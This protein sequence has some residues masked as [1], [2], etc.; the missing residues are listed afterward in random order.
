MLSAL[1]SGSEIAFI[2][3]NK[4]GIEVLKNKGHKRGDLIANFYE[5]PREF[6]SAMVVGN[7]IVLVILTMLATSFLESYLLIYF[8]KDS[9]FLV[10]LITLVITV[11][12]LIFGEF[13]PKILSKLYSNEMLYR[14]AHLLNFFLILLKV[15]TW[16]MTKLSSGVLRLMNVSDENIGNEFSRVDLEVYLHES[17][18]QEQ[19]IDKEILSNVLNLN[20]L[21]V[22]DCYIPRNEIIYIDKSDSVDTAIKLFKEHKI[23]RIIVI[24][25][26]IEDIV[27]Y[28]HHQ[29]L[30]S[31]PKRL[32]KIILPITFIPE[33][34]ALPDAMRKF[35][36][37]RNSISIVVDEFGGVSGLITLE[38]I[39]EEIFGEIEDEHDEEDLFEQKISDNEYLFAGRLEIDYINE[40]YPELELPEGEYQTLSGY[41]VSIEQNIPEE[42][43][44]IHTNGLY[45]IIDKVS[46]TKIEL[47][48]VLRKNQGDNTQL[49]K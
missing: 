33:A 32:D 28:I 29:Q 20:T 8:E 25:D 21:K 43:H 48:K 41:L 44:E 18:S 34:M 1:F 40:K 22:R 11:F 46:E 10:F 4:L 12:V 30:L 7:N 49:E 6:I 13:L 15:P 31:N 37:E 16:F 5:K 42:G 26:D 14:T 9:L 39:L 3:A 35:I 36:L 19:D 45:F 38:D 23:S 27:G 47:V 17:V 24:N 2:S